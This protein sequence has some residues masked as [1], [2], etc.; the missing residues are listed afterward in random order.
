MRT[1]NFLGNPAA[2]SLLLRIGLAG[3]WISHG[4]ILK[5]L[6]FGVVGL[7]NWLAAIGLPS[8]LAL[9]LILA[10]TIGG[11]LIL[12]GIYGRWVSLALLPILLGALLIHAG[13]GW[14]FSNPDGGWEYPLFLAVMT[15]VHALLGDGPLALKAAGATS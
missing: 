9:P 3:M 7:G 15:L 2:A 5:L 12:L 8:A 4:L 1:F 10:E 14:V 6:T 13:N 11:L